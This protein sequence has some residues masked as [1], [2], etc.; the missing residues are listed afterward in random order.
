MNRLA[1]AVCIPFIFL[2]CRERK[3]AAPA[4]P[5]PAM[6]DLERDLR[7]VVIDTAFPRRYHNPDSVIIVR[8]PTTTRD[9]LKFDD[10]LTEKGFIYELCRPDAGIGQLR[11][12]TAESF[13]R[14]NQSSVNL[15]ADDFGNVKWLRFIDETGLKAYWK[16]G[17]SSEEG[18][19]ALRKDYPTAIGLVELSAFGWSN[20]RSEGVIYV[21]SLTITGKGSGEFYALR[22]HGT[23]YACDQLPCLRWITK[24]NKPVMSRQSHGRT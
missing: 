4:A 21:G 11:T 3:V 15:N 14:A 23:Q 10:R 16:D 22:R 2:S 1:F 5:P 13:I 17:R 18:W 20:D 7:L 19:E 24:T 6:A 9:Y 8:T 12:E